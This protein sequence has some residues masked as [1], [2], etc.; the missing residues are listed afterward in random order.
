[1]GSQENYQPFGFLLKGFFVF[2]II[3]YKKEGFL[4][5]M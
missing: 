4:E 3:L 5:N 1:M 2:R